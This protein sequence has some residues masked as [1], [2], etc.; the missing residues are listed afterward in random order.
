MKNFS[1]T[2]NFV[3]INNHP[4]IEERMDLVAD[5]ICPCVISHT[6]KLSYTYNDH[7]LF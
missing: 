6:Q 4:V 1:S 7:I 2:L 5:A 3:S